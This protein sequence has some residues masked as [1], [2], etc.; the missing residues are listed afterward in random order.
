MPWRPGRSLRRPLI[1]LGTLTVA[2]IALS[3]LVVGCASPEPHH[4]VVRIGSAAVEFRV[5]LAQTADQQKEGL[6]GRESL[7]AGTGMLFQF[8]S[9]SEQQVWMAGATIPLDVAWIVD[10]TV[11]AVDT[12]PPCTETD[13][14]KCQVWTSPGPVDSLL[15]VPAQAL[16]AVNT[17]MSITVT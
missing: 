16:Q 14:T 12:L 4:A 1:R 15:E 9:R 8:G 7:P 2:M 5:E 11:L 17:G 3:A 13:H 6:G 10:G